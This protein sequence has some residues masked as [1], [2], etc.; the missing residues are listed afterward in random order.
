M[1][2]NYDGV[3]KVGEV[4]LASTPAQLPSRS[5]EASM[6]QRVVQGVR[7]A[8]RRK[9]PNPLKPGPLT[10]RAARSASVRDQEVDEQ[11]RAVNDGGDHRPRETMAGSM[12]NFFSSGVTQ[13]RSI[14]RWRPPSARPGSPAAHAQCPHHAAAAIVGADQHRLNSS[15]V[16]TAG[17]SRNRT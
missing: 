4:S 12:R 14:P 3:L 6:S 8:L 2:N 1:F 9:V 17:T 11:T 7:P 16:I 15:L 13:R 10:S 5:A